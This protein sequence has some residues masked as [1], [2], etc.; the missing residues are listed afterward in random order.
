MKLKWKDPA[1][2]LKVLAN[3]IAVRNKSHDLRVIERAKSLVSEGKKI[4]FMDIKPRE[5]HSPDLVVVDPINGEVWLEDVKTSHGEITHVYRLRVFPM[6]YLL[7]D[8][9]DR[10]QVSVRGR[11]SEE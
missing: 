1:F 4:P 5:V 8:E 7:S 3:S 9:K 10:R 6:P 2:R 11:N